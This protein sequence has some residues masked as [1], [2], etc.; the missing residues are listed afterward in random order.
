VLWKTRVQC[1]LSLPEGTAKAPG[2]H[3]LYINSFFNMTILVNPRSKISNVRDRRVFTMRLPFCEAFAGWHLVRSAETDRGIR[4][5]YTKKQQAP[6][7]SVFLSV[8]LPACL[9]V[10]LSVLKY[11]SMLITLFLSKSLALHIL[12]PGVSLMW[13]VSATTCRYSAGKDTRCSL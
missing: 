7:L 9:S 1:S 11:W 12:D 8:C 5:A 13:V 3:I 10:C 6:F 4:I 2:Y